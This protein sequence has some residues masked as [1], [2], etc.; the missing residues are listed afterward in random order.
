MDEPQ[1]VPLSGNAGRQYIDACAAF[2]ALD[3]ARKD[4]GTVRG[5]M[6]WREQ[7]G[8]EYLIRQTGGN[9]QTSLGPRSEKTEAIYQNFVQRKA[10]TEA[11]LRKLE[12]TVAEHERMNRVLRVGRAPRMLVSILSSLASWSP[13]KRQALLYDHRR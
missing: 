4:A 7:S 9:R 10:T 5:T 13:V 2:R 6:H 12:T 3:Q 1:I 11:R 8:N